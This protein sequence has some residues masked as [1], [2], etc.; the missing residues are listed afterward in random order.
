M[1]RPLAAT[2]LC[3]AL[4]AAAAP[5]PEL[6]PDG[7]RSSAYGRRVSPPR[8]LQPLVECV[9]RKLAHSLRLV[10]PRI[11]APAARRRVTMNA[12]SGGRTPSSASD[13]AVDLLRESGA[14]FISI[15]ATHLAESFDRGGDLV[16]SADLTGLDRTERQ[17]HLTESEHRRP[18][19]FGDLGYAYRGRADVETDRRVNA[20]QLRIREAT[21]PQ[22]R[23]NRFPTL[24]RGHQ[25]DQHRIAPE[26]RFDHVLIA[27]ALCRHDHRRCRGHDDVS[28]SIT[29]NEFRLPA[30]VYDHGR[31][32]VREG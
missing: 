17:R 8:P 5:D 24:S 19:A 2:V 16:R 9:E 28:D 18:I 22:I 3:L 14:Q 12:S 15:D 29:I 6:E 20:R 21:I 23:T 26:H 13:P 27:V 7:L 31:Q 1:I 25:S 30:Q 11:T 10:L 32:G 4:A